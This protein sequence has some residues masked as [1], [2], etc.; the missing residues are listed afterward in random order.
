[1]NSREGLDLS[2]RDRTPKLAYLLF[3]FVRIWDKRMAS[4]QVA[5]KKLAKFSMNGEGL[6]V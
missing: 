1:V 2:K 5:W 6:C 3:I 4:I